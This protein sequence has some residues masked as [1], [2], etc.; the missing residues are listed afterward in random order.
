MDAPKALLVALLASLALATVVRAQPRPRSHGVA[1]E[2][3]AAS[4]NPMGAENRLDVAVRSELGDDHDLFTQGTHVEGGVSTALSPVYAYAGG[5][6]QVSPLSFLVLRAD[7]QSAGVW[8][9]GMSGAGYYGLSGYDAAVNGQSLVA[10]EGGSAGGWSASAAVTLQGAVDLDE[11]VRLLVGSELDVVRTALGDRA[12]SY[13]MRHDAILA[14][15]DTLVLSS[16]FLGAELAPVSDFVVRFGAYD[17]LRH[18]PASGY[19]GHQLGPLV[20]VEWHHVTRE[21][22]SLGIFVRAGAYTHHVYRTGEA[23]VAAG[24]SIDFDLGD[25]R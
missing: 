24:L 3:L 8:P 10:E 4:L 21:V 2:Q 6:V 25:L 5:Y 1:H 7:V 18:V 9:I 15:E 12:F 14:R 13:S 16:S 11:G 22:S 19:V 20:M 17:D 23:T